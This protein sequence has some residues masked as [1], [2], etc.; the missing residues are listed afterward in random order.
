MRDSEAMCLGQCG[1]VGRVRSV[2]VVSREREV[3][4][5]GCGVWLRWE[6]CCD[7]GRVSGAVIS[8]ASAR[9]GYEG[10]T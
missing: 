5:G 9:G 10:R 4:G 1:P 3:G 2:T 6:D 7:E 8:G